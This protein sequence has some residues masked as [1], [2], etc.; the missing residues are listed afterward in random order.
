MPEQKIIKGTD[1]DA[2]WQQLNLDLKNND[3]LRYNAAIE[4]GGKR[5]FLD[6]DIDLGGGFESGY[7]TTTL[8][9]PVRTTNG[10]KFAIHQ[11]HFID[12]IGKFFGMQ[13]VVIGYPEFDER[14]II[15][16]NDEA[17]VKAL[18][19]DTTVRKVL[20]SL[21][22][23]TFEIQH[24]ESVEVPSQLQ[25][26]IEDAI[27]EPASLRCVYHAFYEVLVIVDAE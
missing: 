3:L 5:L 20:A 16:T 25:L 23:F 24:D 12:D 21:P 7:A 18:F 2:V 19:A 4:Q 15:K 17:K 27:T 10:F 26:F 13:D 6:I 1:E 8:T 11:Q 9:A 14:F 22:D